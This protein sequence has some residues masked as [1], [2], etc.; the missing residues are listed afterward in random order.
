MLFF[1]PLLPLFTHSAFIRQLFL[2]QLSLQR[3]DFVVKKWWLQFEINFL[4]DNSFV[5][6]YSSPM[7]TAQDNRIF[8]KHKMQKFGTIART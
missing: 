3:T 1:F 4:K 6:G 5:R 2:D 8:H 7:K